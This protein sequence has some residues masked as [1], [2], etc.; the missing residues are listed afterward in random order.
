[1]KKYR[2]LCLLKKWN[3]VKYPIH[4]PFF[5]FL[6]CNAMLLASTLDPHHWYD[7][8]HFFN[9]F[10]L[11]IAPC[12]HWNL[13]GKRDTEI[14]T[15]WV[16]NFR[17]ELKQKQYIGKVKVIAKS[18]A[19]LNPIRRHLKTKL[20]SVLFIFTFYVLSNPHLQLHSLRYFLGPF[21]AS[22]Q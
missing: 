1:M 21:N 2:Y 22:F 20:S 16:M 7:I 12:L 5:L 14:Y 4:H 19:L 11:H 10:F 17:G 15:C 3:Q 6:F 8:W 9:H 18:K 13:L